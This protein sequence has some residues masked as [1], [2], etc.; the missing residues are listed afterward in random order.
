M[1]E[2]VGHHVLPH[3]VVFT[4]SV[5]MP[6]ATGGGSW[7]GTRPAAAR[8]WSQV[9]ALTFAFGKKYEILVGLEV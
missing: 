4:H 5:S 9:V 2:C 3:I 8:F 6:R 7:E 1:P